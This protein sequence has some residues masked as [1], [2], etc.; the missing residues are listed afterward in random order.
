MGKDYTQADL[1]KKTS[2]VRNSNIELRKQGKGGEWAKVLTAGWE[3]VAGK[4]NA[5]QCAPKVCIWGT[6]M[7]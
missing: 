7:V 2:C 5:R 3:P 6:V 1:G 4:G